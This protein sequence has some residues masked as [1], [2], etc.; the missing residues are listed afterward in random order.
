MLIDFRVFG[1]NVL[2]SREQSRLTL[3]TPN[4]PRGII[5]TWKSYLRTR[6]NN[7]EVIGVDTSEA[8]MKHDTWFTANK[9]GLRKLIEHLPKEMVIYELTQNVW[10][11]N[12]SYCSITI[13]RDPGSAYV[14]ITCE[15]DVPE[16][17][18]DLSHAFTIWAESD[19]KADPTKRGR[20][21]EGE[22]KVLALC[23]R[24]EI[25]TTTGTVTF[26]EDGTR[27]T[28][29]RKRDK[30]SLFYG[31]LRLTNQQLAEVQAAFRRLIP[32]NNC[33]TTLNGHPLKLRK[34]IAEF[35]ETLPT[36]NVDDEGQLR[37][38]RRKTT[39]RVYRPENGETAMLYECGIPVVET[40]DAFHI[41]VEQKVPLNRDRDNVTP[42]YLRKIRAA[43]LIHTVDLMDA[44]EITGKGVDDAME[45]DLV[46]K[47]TM[48][49]VLRKRHGRKHAFHDHGDLEA[50]KHLHGDGYE[51][52][53]RGSYS[54]KVR[55]KLLDTG[56]AKRSGQIRPT[57]HPFSDD[58]NAPSMKT[59]HPDHWMTG[60]KEVAEI[61]RFLAKELGIH[62]DLLVTF[63]LP[64]QRWWRAAW[65]GGFTWNV[66]PLGRKWFKEW[67]MHPR[68]LLS[69]IIHEFAHKGAPDHLSNDYHRNCTRIGSKLAMFMAFE[70]RRIP[71]WKKVKQHRKAL[72]AA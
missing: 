6:G 16:G 67:Y 28:S 34:P 13:E 43:A 24:A 35:T 1:K 70:A 44:E 68:T 57:P 20:F 32:P 18:K 11:E 33:R 47:E 51:I 59:I 15:D 62:E 45:D 17:F 10:D 55:T 2:S 26:N 5:R 72:E 58:P 48:V 63:G 12:A 19:K 61:C 71:H 66:N 38:T 36:V 39:V 53:P 29:S 37:P 7:P 42:A 54:S 65:G 25:S 69:I 9:D 60:M 23:R 46:E 40:G 31:E 4:L 50:N 21:N 22:K 14:K 8:D 52:I 64:P 30:G 41:S 3:S 27:T 56:S 49:K